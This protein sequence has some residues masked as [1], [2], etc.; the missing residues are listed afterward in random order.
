MSVAVVGSLAGTIIT[1]A[2]FQ[3]NDKHAL[4]VGGSESNFQVKPIILPNPVSG[5]STI[6][7]AI[8]GDFNTASKPCYTARTF[9]NLI[10]RP[11]ILT[12][13][14]CQRNNYYFNESFTNPKFVTGKVSLYEPALPAGFKGTYHSVDGYSGNAEQLG[15]NSE[16]CKAAA[17]NNDPTSLQ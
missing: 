14:L 6:L 11:L 13:G 10:N 9:H 5:P 12:N 1:T 7:E 2:Q 15:Q 8:D 17:A 16:T 3:P 4:P